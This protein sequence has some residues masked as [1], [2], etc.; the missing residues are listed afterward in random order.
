M[1]LIE[2]P[3]CQELVKHIDAAVQHPD[4]NALTTAMRESLCGLIRESKVRLPDCVFESC[5]GHYA[6]RELYTSDRY[7]YSIVAMTWGPGQGTPLHDHSGMWCVEGVWQGQLEITQYELLEQRGDRFHF[8]SCG[9]VLAGTGSAGCL[10]PPHEYHTIHNRSDAPA[11]S[12]HI[13][14]NAMT[15]CSVFR[16]LENNEWFERDSRVME[17]DKLN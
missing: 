3:G 16:P 6:R 2:F 12:V 10:I 4:T 14:R 1:F 7:G 5:T 11:V 13:Y 9:A 17:L 15:S 8:Q